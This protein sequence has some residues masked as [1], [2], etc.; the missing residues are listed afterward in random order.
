MCYY[1][2]PVMHV[3]TL[4]SILKTVELTLL[5][6]QLANMHGG[7]IWL[8]PT[9]AQIISIYILL[10]AIKRHIIQLYANCGKYS[11][12]FFRHFH[13]SRVAEVL[14]RKSSLWLVSTTYYCVSINERICIS[15]MG[16]QTY[17]TKWQ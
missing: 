11:G 5:A 3:F 13:T 15:T 6:W 7:I 8:P 9:C 4:R 2:R 16:K 17:V 1:G 12:T 10:N 14:N